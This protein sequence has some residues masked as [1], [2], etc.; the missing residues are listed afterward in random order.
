MNNP[1]NKIMFITPL[2]NRFS[3]LLFIMLPLMIC[4]ACGGNAFQENY[5]SDIDEDKITV[6]IQTTPPIFKMGYDIQGDKKRLVKQ[7]YILIGHSHV[8]PMMGS[9]GKAK[10][11][12]A[13]VNATLV[14][15]Y[16]SRVKVGNRTVYDNIEGKIV[17][18]IYSKYSAYYY[19]KS[20]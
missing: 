19:V 5:N 13:L 17:F 15:F 14:M 3:K 6:Q 16:Y 2:F 9:K 20:E 8:G 18:N 11:M 12:G 4:V 1:L 7:G 10:R